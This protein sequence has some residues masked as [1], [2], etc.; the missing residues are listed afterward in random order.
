MHFE[1][2]RNYGDIVRLAI[3]VQPIETAAFNLYVA[4]TYSGPY[5]ILQ[6]NIRNQKDRR[7]PSRA[8]TVFNKSELG[9]T[10]KPFYLKMTE[11]DRGG[12]ESDVEDS[13]YYYVAASYPNTFCETF[14]VSDAEVTRV[15]FGFFTKE[16]S[17]NTLSGSFLKRFFIISPLE[18]ELEKF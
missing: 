12:V 4:D 14:E 11:V 8:F 15:S 1:I 3:P 16:I 2:D 13:H 6:T 10:A 7:V 18:T 17:I 5:S 9:L